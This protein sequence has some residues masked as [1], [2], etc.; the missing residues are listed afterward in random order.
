MADQTETNLK[1]EITRLRNLAK[2]KPMCLT[3]KLGVLA[4]VKQK[5]AAL[6]EYRLG[7]V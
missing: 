1:R 6:R 2:T 3:Q 7:K 5:E 4:R